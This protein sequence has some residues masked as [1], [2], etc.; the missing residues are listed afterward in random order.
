MRIAQGLMTPSTDY[1]SRERFVELERE[2]EAFQRFF[3]GQWKITKK[4]IKREVYA[5]SRAK[6]KQEDNSDSANTEL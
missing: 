6:T 5:E 1:S 4:E 3:K 2:F